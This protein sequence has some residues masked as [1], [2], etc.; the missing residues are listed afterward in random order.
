[1]L[2]LLV[3]MGML[4]IAQLKSW[5][6]YFILVASVVAAIITPPDALSMAAM[7]GAMVV[8]YEL[9]IFLAQFFAPKAAKDDAPT[10]SDRN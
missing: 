2:V 4:T 1:M 8:L 5:R 7:L 10:E 9:G 3:K 6:G